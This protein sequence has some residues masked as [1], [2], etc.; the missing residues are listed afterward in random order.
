MSDTASRN[1]SGAAQMMADALL[2]T[3]AGATA[4]LQVTTAAA[5]TTQ[6]ELGIVATSFSTVA[7]SPAV[8]RKLRP[9]WRRGDQPEWE[10]LLSATSVQQQVNTLDLPSAQALFAMTL[11]V[12]MGGQN[13]VIESI[14]SN[15]ALGQTYLYRLLLKEARAQSI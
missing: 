12:A 8:L 9:T 10:M 2:R 11:G 1:P 5:D 7:V 15:E 14:A 3:V 4:Y 13:F 6:N